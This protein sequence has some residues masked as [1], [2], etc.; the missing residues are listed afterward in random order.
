MITVPRDAGSLV[1]ALD[2]ILYPGFDPEGDDADCGALLIVQGLKDSLR[3]SIAVGL[4]DGDGEVILVD[5]STGCRVT[6]P[7]VFRRDETPPPDDVNEVLAW[8]DADNGWATAYRG[9]ENRDGI[10]HPDQNWCP[11]W[12]VWSYGITAHFK[13]WR[14]APPAPPGDV[15]SQPAARTFSD[16]PRELDELACGGSLVPGTTDEFVVHG[17]CSGRER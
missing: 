1:Q 2:R 17:T 14:R 7:D 15:K 5:L 11:C 4:S 3:G 12:W 16:S 8:E 9:G 10:A 13:W 6:D